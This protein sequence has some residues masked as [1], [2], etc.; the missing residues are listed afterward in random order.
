[1]RN[2]VYVLLLFVLVGCNKY[3]NIYVY[4]NYDKGLLNASEQ[5]QRILLVFDFLGN[6]NN[7]AKKM[8]YSQEFEG[9]LKNTTVIVLN[10]DEPGKDGELNKDLQKTKYGTDIQPMYYLLNSKGELI[11]TPLEYCTK[12]EFRKFIE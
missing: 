1:M 4:N 11:K 8:I 3:S 2:L 10:I 6:P 9:M 12:E 7:S 5:N